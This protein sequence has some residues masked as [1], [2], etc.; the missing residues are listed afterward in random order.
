[1]KRLLSLLFL[2]A[3]LMLTSCASS[4]QEDDPL[5]QLIIGSSPYAPYFYRDVSGSY[6]GIDVEIAA[7]ACRRIGY[8][9]VF[10]EIALDERFARLA[11][12]EV[13]CLWSCLTMD[14][15]E[16]EFLWAGPYLYTQ[17]VIVV[18]ADSGIRSIEDLADQRVAVQSGSTSEHILTDGLDNEFSALA[19]LTV[20]PELGQ[21]FAALRG[22]YVD[23]A[24]GMEGALKQY[25]DDYPGEYRLLNM[26]FRSQAQG[27]AFRKNGDTALAQKLR[28]ALADMTADGTTAAIISAHGLNVKKNVYGGTTNADSRCAE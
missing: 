1:M 15:R 13:D 27:V 26:R 14:S 3:V 5:P 8:E 16:D 12:G 20:Y 6:A 23:A 7:E 19:R 2:C 10:R 18:R 4:P 24:A 21:V 11:A 22:G 9:P 17:R 25:L 28:D